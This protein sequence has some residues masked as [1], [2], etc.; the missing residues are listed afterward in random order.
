MKLAALGVVTFVLGAVL[1]I[2]GLMWIGVLW[3][4]LMYVT[5]VVALD[6]FFLVT[7][8]PDVATLLQPIYDLLNESFIINWL[9]QWLL[10]IVS[11][12]LT[13]FVP[14]H[15]QAFLEF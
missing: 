14:P 4:A 9:N 12:I 3:V 15:V 2:P 5:S 7:D 6:T 8:N 10:P 11:F 1:S 13:P